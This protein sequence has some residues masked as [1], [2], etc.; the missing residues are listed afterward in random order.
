MDKIKV[1]MVDDHA[2]MRQGL[3]ALLNLYDDVEVVGEASNGKEAIVKTQELNPNVV[4]MDISMPH[5]NGIEATR[6]IVRH[7]P[8]VK[9]VIITQYDNHE[10]LISSVKAGALGYLPKDC[11]GADLI[12]AI[13]TVHRGEWFLHPSVFPDLIKDYL[14]QTMKE[15][16]ENLTV[17]ELEVLRLVAEGQTSRQIADNLAISLKTVLTIRANIMK[18]L[19]L[20]NHFELFKYAVGKGLVEMDG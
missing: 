12:L 6:H 11:S 5:M 4:L 15:T 18:K 2:I 19:G 14:H 9:I 3:R 10:Y 1:L 13:R 20:H 8:E 16:Q 7:N 17:R